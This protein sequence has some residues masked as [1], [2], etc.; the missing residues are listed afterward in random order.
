MLSDT[1]L[2]TNPLWVA[3]V[4]L[5]SSIFLG[6][7]VNNNLASM[8]QLL[9]HELIARLC[10]RLIIFLFTSPCHQLS[11]HTQQL[12][13]ITHA[14]TEQNCT[15]LSF[16]QAW[17][18][19]NSSRRIFS[20]QKDSL[21]INFHLCW[22]DR[23]KVH[24]RQH[25]LKQIQ[26]ATYYVSMHRK[27]RPWGGTKPITAMDHHLTLNNVMDPGSTYQIHPTE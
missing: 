23:F 7:L 8:P 18:S 15:N 25:V 11:S 21:A 1:V 2:T 20:L 5:L 12:Q 19:C 16:S 3:L 17:Y 24:L 27:T 13:F 6:V 26:Y 10:G 9:L 4:A 22:H 14:P